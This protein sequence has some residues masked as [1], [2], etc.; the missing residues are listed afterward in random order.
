[1]NDQL[2]RNYIQDTLDK[3][4]NN[5]NKLWR[6]IRKIWASAKNDKSTR[7]KSSQIQCDAHTISNILNSHFSSVGENIAKKIDN[8]RIEEYY[9]D[10]H[11][12]TF[13]LETTT[14][15][16]VAE[17]MDQS[18]SSPSCG[19]DGITAYLCENMQS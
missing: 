14:P 18:S 15:T 8:V 2:K 7:I 3:Y 16:I 17:C 9:P 13:D 10:F 11:P 6:N 1:M 5:A 12:P 4:K 19:F